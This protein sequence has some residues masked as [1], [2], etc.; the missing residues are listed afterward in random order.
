MYPGC[1]STF[2]RGDNLKGHYISK[3]LLA[4]LGKCHS[5]ERMTEVHKTTIEELYETL[6]LPLL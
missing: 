4:V 3:L 5:L 1:K 6:D 2:T